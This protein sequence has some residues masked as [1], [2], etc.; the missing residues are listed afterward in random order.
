MLDLGHNRIGPRG[1]AALAASPYLANLRKIGVE[2]CGIG[3]AARAAFERRF[4]ED[5]LDLRGR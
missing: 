5:A 1:G 3:Q 4:G 2:G